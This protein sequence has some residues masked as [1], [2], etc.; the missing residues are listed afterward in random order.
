MRLSQ[1]FAITVSGLL[2]MGIATAIAV[3]MHSGNR[4]HL[5]LGV[6][7]GENF[8]VHPMSLPSIHDTT[9]SGRFEVEE[10]STA[11]H[12]R[13]SPSAEQQPSL[14]R[15]DLEP[16]LAAPDP[17]E[18]RLV[19]AV[20]SDHADGGYLRAATWTSESSWAGDISLEILERQ[21]DEIRKLTRQIEMLQKVM[22]EK[23]FDSA[24]RSRVPRPGRIHKGRTPTRRMTATNDSPI[25]TLPRKSGPPTPNMPATVQRSK[26]CWIAWSG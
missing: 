7:S 20:A 2:G 8:T 6:D 3:F 9:D 17:T 25:C 18:S 1:V 14:S 4:Y 21:T 5:S 19:N 11:Y 10:D 16:V 26:G 23:P 12:D 24:A 13:R 15:S 22:M